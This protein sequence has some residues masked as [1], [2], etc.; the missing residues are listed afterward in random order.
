MQ[1]APIVSIIC[2]TY[3]HEKYI[4]HALDGFLMQHTDFTFEILI[5]DDASTDST[6]DIIRNYAE[7]YPNIIKPILQDKNQFGKGVNVTQ[8]FQ[9]P[10]AKGKYIAVCEGDDYWIDANKLQL[11]VNWLECHPDDIGCVHKYIVVDEDEN[12]QNIKT[13]GY[14]EHEERYTL[15][16]FENKELPSQLAS[17]MFRN[18]VN[19]PS[20]KYPE[21]F[22][23]IKIQ[24]DIKLFLYLL[25]YGSIYRMPQVCSAY[26]FVF[27]KGGQSWSSRSIGTVRGYRDWIALQ[28]LEQA[29]FEKYGQKVFLKKRKVAAAATTVAD[30]INFRT[31]NNLK[32]AVTV[33]FRQKGCLS[34]VVQLAFR[35]LKIKLGINGVD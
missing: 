18:I 10:R 21:L 1:D 32:N 27:H 14:Y 31:W 8:T 34:R 22:N 29:F 6:A 12:I 20:T 16:D 15:K 7:R 26:R 13:F 35:K 25:A 11:Q 24:G 19:D 5:H 28:E 17:L 2:N 9:Y 33:I 23:K 3:N 4:A 30:F